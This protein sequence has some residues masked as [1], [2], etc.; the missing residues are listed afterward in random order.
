MDPASLALAFNI[1]SAAVG[2]IGAAIVWLLA[3]L[4]RKSEEFNANFNRYVLGMERRAT[5][6][7][8]YLAGKD[9]NFRPLQRMSDS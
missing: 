6:I 2:L 8:G 1:W 9:Q 7:E 5:H 3:R 4:L